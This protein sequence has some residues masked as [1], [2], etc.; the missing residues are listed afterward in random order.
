MRPVLYVS[1]S[2]EINEKGKNLDHIK[3]PSVAYGWGLRGEEALQQQKAE[4]G[5]LIHLMTTSV[6]E[7]SYIQAQRSHKTIK[8]MILA[9][10]LVNWGNRNK[11]PWG[12]NS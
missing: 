10:D 12:I 7:S 6:D 1:P 5:N 2:R 8:L 4:L 11:C 9:E 3:E